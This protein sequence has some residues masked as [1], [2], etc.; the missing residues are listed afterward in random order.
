MKIFTLEEII[1]SC[2]KIKTVDDL[3]ANF[4]VIIELAKDDVQR[5]AQSKN[6]FFFDFDFT[7]NDATKMLKRTIQ[8]THLRAVQKFLT[9]DNV[10]EAARWVCQR[11]LNNMRNITT[12]K[13]YKLYLGPIV[14][15]TEDYLK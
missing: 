13:N 4:D 2:S 8:K 12:N 3:L 11:L 1:K 6:L 9:C 5:I 15:T 14:L 10:D 7:Y